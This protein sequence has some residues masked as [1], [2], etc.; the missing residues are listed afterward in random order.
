MEIV[1]KKVAKDISCSLALEIAFFCTAIDVQYLGTTIEDKSL[2]FNLFGDAFTA[3]IYN[4][5]F[6]Q[7]MTGPEG[8]ESLTN[9]LCNHITDHQKVVAMSISS[10]PAL[11]E[12]TN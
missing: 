5:Q 12:R 8:L 7:S 6:K 2:L 3:G 11:H 9:K 1:N 10:H 4:T